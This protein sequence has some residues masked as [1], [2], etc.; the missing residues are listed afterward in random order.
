MRRKASLC[1]LL[2]SNNDSFDM[3]RAHRSA[4]SRPE[5]TSSE[6]VSFSRRLR[7]SKISSR[8]SC[9]FC[10]IALMSVRFIVPSFRNGLV[11]GSCISRY[12]SFFHSRLEIPIFI[13]KRRAPG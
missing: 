7:N 2:R 5:S 8:W 9:S 3:L 12:S 1:W 13:L 6:R 11:Y 4:T 10:L